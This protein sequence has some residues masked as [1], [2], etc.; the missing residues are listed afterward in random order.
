MTDQEHPYFYNEVGEI[1]FI[2]LAN[3][4]RFNL[5]SRRYMA[6]AIF[7]AVY[8][9][10]ERREGDL[11]QIDSESRGHPAVRFQSPFVSHH[12]PTSACESPAVGSGSVSDWRKSF[13]VIAYT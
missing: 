7:N 13:K 6:H 5:D 10:M 12:S 9:P 4:S 11:A 8:K 1:A 3:L 2:F